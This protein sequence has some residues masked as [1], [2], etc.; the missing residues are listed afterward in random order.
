MIAAVCGMQVVL[1]FSPTKDYLR[2][3]WPVAVVT[4]LVLVFYMN[5]FRHFVEE[6]AVL[7]EGLGP[8]GIGLKSIKAYI[9]KGIQFITTFNVICFA[10]L[11]L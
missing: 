2:P 5:C 7:V 9:P 8:S 10:D 1:R 11:A 6:L 4:V 3:R